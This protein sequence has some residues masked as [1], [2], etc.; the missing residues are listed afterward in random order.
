[1]RSLRKWRTT[2]RS[3]APPRGFR[4]RSRGRGLRLVDA[5]RA[6]RCEGPRGPRR[7][8][9]P[10]SYIDLRSK[11][12][13]YNCLIT[14]SYQRPSGYLIGVKQ[15]C[16]NTTIHRVVRAIARRS[17]TFI[18]WPTPEEMRVSADFFYE[19]YGLPN[20]AMGVDGDYGI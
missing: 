16:S 5:D 11:F 15:A 8:Q 12:N 1:M 3:A 9:A 7:F 18:T 10:F 14:A 20:I 6:P 2:S 19:K 13:H 17:A 4:G